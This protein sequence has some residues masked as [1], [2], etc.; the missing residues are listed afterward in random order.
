M[1]LGT[2]RMSA[3]ERLICPLQRRVFAAHMR[4][5]LISATLSPGMEDTRIGTPSV[6]PNFSIWEAPCDDGTSGW[7]W[8]GVGS[9]GL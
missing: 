6:R 5:V 9:C 4:R 7:S 2:A 1:K 3:K 8:A